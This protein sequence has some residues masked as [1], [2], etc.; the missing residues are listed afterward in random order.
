[1][2]DSLQKMIGVVVLLIAVGGVSCDAALNTWIASN[3]DDSAS[4]AELVN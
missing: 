3:S 2:P 1:M 4:R